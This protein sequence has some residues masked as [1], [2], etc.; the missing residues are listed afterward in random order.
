[1]RYLLHRVLSA[2]TKPRMRLPLTGRDVMSL[3]MRLDRPALEELDHLHLL[4]KRHRSV[5]REGVAPPRGGC[6]A[7]IALTGGLRLGRHLR[8]RRSSRRSARRSG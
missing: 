2:D 1:M 3:D 4:D 5:L 8:I 6:G 7:F